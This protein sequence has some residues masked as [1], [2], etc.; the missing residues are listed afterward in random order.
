MATEITDPDLTRALADPRGLIVLPLSEQILF[1]HTVLAV[2][3]AQPEVIEVLSG[4]GDNS[5]IVAVRVR[6]PEHGTASLREKLAGVGTVARLHRL[7]ELATREGKSTVVAFVEGV[8]RVRIGTER[9]TA[10]HLRVSVEHLIERHALPDA[11]QAALRRTIETLFSE[12]LDA[13]PGAAPELPSTWKEVEDVSALTD[14]IAWAMPDISQDVR[15][16]LLETLDVRERMWRLVREMVR[17]RDEQRAVN[18]IREEA[19][20]QISDAQRRYFLE[21]QVRALR[22]EL[23]QEP[24]ESEIEELRRGIEEKALPKHAADEAR[25][26]LARLARMPREAT[27]HALVRT[28]LEWLIELPWTRTSNHEIDV[29]QAARVLDEDHDDLERVKERVLEY[30]SVIRLKPDQKG[31]ILCFVG[32]PGVGKT[33]LGRSIARALGRPFVR[34]SLG[35][36]HDEAEIRGHRRTYVGAMPG[37]ILRGIRQAGTSDPVFMLDE[38]DKLGKDFRGDPAAALLEVLDPE[39]NVTFTDNYLGVPFDLS[40]VMFLT[41]ANDLDP[42]PPALRDRMEALEL[43]GYVDEEKLTIAKHH[44]VP[45]QREA[46]GLAQE[47]LVLGDDALADIVRHYTDE[48]GVRDLERRI[49]SLCR[50][51]A[52]QI[53]DSG[54]GAAWMTRDRVR[55]LLGPAPFEQE[56]DLAA[57]TSIPGVSVA[58]AWTPRGGEVLFVEASRMTRARG[59]LLVTGQVGKVMFESARIALSWVRA[60][61]ERYGIDPHLVNRSDL[62]VH[63]PAG[64]VKKDGPSAGIVIAAAFVSLFT[65]RSIRPYVAMTGEITLSGLLMKVGGMKG[66]MLAARRNG[67]REVILPAQ[68]R[69]EVFEEVPEALRAQT[70]LHFVATMGEAIDL[71]L[72]KGELGRAMRPR[73]LVVPRNP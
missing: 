39:Q 55:E 14:L 4:L 26:E 6:D 32:P 46:H 47:Q 42:V 45:K 25:R 5:L 33:S 7:V 27:E 34:I 49:A 44:L 64:A 56:L 21:E 65:G 63:V 31:P 50:K 36:M 57:R 51:R 69:Q 15:Q 8:A 59:E 52:R 22:R 18:R 58:L 10:P 17:V 38:I 68:N 28:Y 11:E 53:V 67:V 54:N 48:S 37:Q 30:L 72:Q 19:K 20:R 12:I 2:A 73:P 16:E 60:H 40:G 61:A 71:A 41:T 35:G 9:R 23:G 62:H 1:P 3:I 70:Q 29:A 24:E 66:K 43:P 13:T